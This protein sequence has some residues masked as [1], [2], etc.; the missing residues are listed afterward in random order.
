[1][2]TVKTIA[3]VAPKSALGVL[4]K[5]TDHDPYRLALDRAT[6]ID[7]RARPVR[8][9]LARIGELRAQAV[10]S[11][12]SVKEA[13]RAVVA[14]VI[15]GGEPGAEWSPPAESSRLMARANEVSAKLQ[16]YQLAAN[17]H[18]ADSVRPAR[19]EAL[20]LAQVGIVRDHFA[21]AVAAMLAG[22]AEFVRHRETVVRMLTELGTAGLDGGPVSMPHFPY[23]LFGHGCDFP[24]ALRQFV[25]EVADSGSITAADAAALA[26][27]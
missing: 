26:G 6:A 5:L 2:S 22:L 8:E 4:P 16:V 9:E 12:K 23:Y 14:H 27:G 25:Q 17:I 24:E 10:A 20:R 18:D 11:E 15:A 7:E 1:M 13:R 19:A 3:R 21:P